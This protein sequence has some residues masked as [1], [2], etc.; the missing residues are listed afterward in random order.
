MALSNALAYIVQCFAITTKIPKCSSD[1]SRAI[2]Q[3]KNRPTFKFMTAAHT[4]IA[5]ENTHTQS[6]I[7]TV[8][9]LR[10]V[11]MRF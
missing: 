1:S 6:Y 5:E 10:L 7:H 3:R 2:T 11:N 9:S 4:L 8:D